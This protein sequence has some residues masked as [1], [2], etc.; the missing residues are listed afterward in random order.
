MSLVPPDSRFARRVAAWWETALT[1]EVRG[2]WLSFG[3]SG[4]ALAELSVLLFSGDD[5]LFTPTR[6]IP[7][8]LNCG[9]ISALS[10]WCATRP[11]PG[12]PLAAR[13]VA[14]AVLVVVAIGLYPRWTAVAHWYVAFSVKCAM[15]QPNGGEQVAMIVTML[16]VPVCLGDTR[17]WQWTRPGGPMAPRFRGAALAG[18][19]AVRIQ[20]AGVYLAA[21]VSKLE[22][23]AWRN[24]KAL[25]SLLYD[26]GYGLPPTIRSHVVGLLGDAGLIRVLTGAVLAAEVTIALALLW[27]PPWQRWSFYLICALHGAIVVVMALPS[28]GVIMIAAGATAQAPARTSQE[29]P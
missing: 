24:G 6:T 5:T 11:V 15:T 21:V 27:P 20:L 9:G 17:R 29:S 18:L 22:A 10:L 1:A 16:L 13:L 25:W 4:L 8:G 23:P 19:F 2:P 26:P 3:R 14:V 7:D 12:A 28:F